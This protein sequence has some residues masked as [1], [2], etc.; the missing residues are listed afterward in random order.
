[1]DELCGVSVT[2]VHQLRANVSISTTR[3]VSGRYVPFMP[4]IPRR[5]AIAGATTFHVYARGV[6][7]MAIFRDDLDRLRFER[8]LRESARRHRWR[9]HGR[10]L[11]TTHFHLVIR[12][13][14]EQLSRGMHLVLFRY[15]QGFNRRYGRWGHVFGGRFQAKPIRTCRYLCAALQYVLDNPVR[16]GLVR[17]GEEWRWGGIGLPP[18]PSQSGR[19]PPQVRSADAPLH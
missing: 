1:M 17:R 12:C 7:S 16:A 3:S 18:R 5:D 19:A 8:L 9:L 4:R 2:E 13:S 14:P 10:Q 11:L 6:A 15:A